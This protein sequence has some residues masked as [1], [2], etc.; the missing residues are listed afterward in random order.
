MKSIT[1]TLILMLC[2]NILLAQSPCEG[3]YSEEIFDQDDPLSNKKR[4]TSAKLHNGE[5]YE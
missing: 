5:E 4:T 3:R 1:K 2:S